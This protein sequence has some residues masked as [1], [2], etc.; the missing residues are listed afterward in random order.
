[1]GIDIRLPIGI[2]FSLLGLILAAY[3]FFGDASRYRQSLDVNI[4]LVWGIVLFAFGFFMLLL[5]RR[6]MRVAPQKSGSQS[7]HSSGHN[8]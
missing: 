8:R 6:G 4:N 7:S 5:G 3:G 1:M 2:L